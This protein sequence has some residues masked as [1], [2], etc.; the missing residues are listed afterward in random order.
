MKEVVF[1]DEGVSIKLDAVEL[2]ALM[3]LSTVLPG[4]LAHKVALAR[5][6]GS[7]LGAPERSAADKAGV[8]ATVSYNL[9]EDQD[10]LEDALKATDMKCLFY[11]IFRDARSAIKHGAPFLGCKVSSQ[12]G[13]VSDEAV[14][15]IEA[16]TSFLRREFAERGIKW[17]L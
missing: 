14:A 6:S 2:E 9:P 15:I 3:R 5:E 7:S 16:V 17:V 8:T 11:D 10:A 13:A 12:N 4:T 1:D